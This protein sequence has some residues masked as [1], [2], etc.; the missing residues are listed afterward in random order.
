MTLFEIDNEILNFPYVIDE[1]T[2][3]VLNADAL[4]EL[5]L[6]RDE[7]IENICCYIKNLRADADAIKNEAESMAQR[8][9]RLNKKADS[10]QRYLEKHLAGEKFDSIRASISWRASKYVDVDETILPKKYFTK[11]ISYAPDKKTL[12]AILKQGGKVKG[13]TLKE[14]NNMTIY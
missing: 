10:L 2:G 8:Y 6:A 11:K 13:A 5:H 12:T 1:E 9:K 7:K 3:E 4:D 14:R